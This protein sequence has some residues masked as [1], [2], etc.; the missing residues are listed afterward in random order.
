MALGPVSLL[1]ADENHLFFL[2]RELSLL[3][4]NALFSY[5][6]SRIDTEAK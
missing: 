4:G 5:T 6:L 2:D 3:V 1:K